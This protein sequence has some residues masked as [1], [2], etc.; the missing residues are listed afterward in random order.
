MGQGGGPAGDGIQAQILDPLCKRRQNRKEDLI[1][2]FLEGY[3]SP[4][5][6]GHDIRRTRLSTLVITGQMNREEALK[7]LEQP[8]LSEEERK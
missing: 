6:F 8:P 1:T 7:V 3:W 4:T 2:K 5:R